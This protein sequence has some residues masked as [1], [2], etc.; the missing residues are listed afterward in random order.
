MCA[1]PSTQ[2]FIG[3]RTLDSFSCLIQVT[4]VRESSPLSDCRSRLGHRHP[5]VVRSRWWSSGYGFCGQQYFLN[6]IIHCPLRPPLLC[7][8][9][10]LF[11]LKVKVSTRTVPLQHALFSSGCPY[12]VTRL[13]NSLLIPDRIRP[14]CCTTTFCHSPRPTPLY[15]EINTPQR[16]KLLRPLQHV[17]LFPLRSPSE[18]SESLHHPPRLHRPTSHQCEVVE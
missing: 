14:P 9:T 5:Y 7:P 8:V 6:I 12:F 13:R 15:R 4:R 3:H 1:S 11:S 10:P 16:D 17:T 2:C 18:S